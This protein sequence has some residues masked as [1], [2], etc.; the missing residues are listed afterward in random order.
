MIRNTL[1]LFIT[2]TLFA[3]GSMKNLSLNHALKMLDK[4]NLEVQ[5][6]RFNE[7]MKLH[8]IAAAKGHN[9]GKLDVSVTGMRSNDAGNVFGFKLQSREATFGDFGFSQF[10][11]SGQTNPLPVQPTALNYPSTR[12]HYQTK[13]SYVLPLYT[14]GKLSEY[15]RITTAMHRMSQYDTQKILNE[16]VFQTKIPRT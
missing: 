10:D 2:T 6:A 11:M 8:E 14:G 13:A 7:Q 3:F 9:Y 12:N 15:G 16:K 1:F 5:V 4:N